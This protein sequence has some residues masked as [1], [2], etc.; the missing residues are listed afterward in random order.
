M[1]VLFIGGTGII[2]S[3]CSKH[4]LANGIDL[5]HLNRGESKSIRPIEG[6]KTLIADVRKPE[7]VAQVIQGHHFDAV[8]DWIAFVPEHIENDIRLFRDKTDQYVFISTA[9]LYQT[10]PEKLPITEE[11]KLENPVW[12]YARN[13]I[14]CEEKLRAE[15]IQSGFP[16]T[17]VRPSHTYDKTLIPM[18]GGYTILKR[19]MD[20]LPVVVHG[21]GASIWTLTHN[22][23]F[24][25]GLIGLLGKKQAINEAYHITS[26]EWQSW[27]TI[28]KTMA[29][30]LG[31]EPD[32]V[33]IPS[34]KIATY[35]RDIGDS[36]LGDKTHSMIFDN[37][38]IKALVPDF[39]AEIPFEQGAQEIAAWYQANPL[40]LEIDQRLNDL[41]EQMI[42]DSR[43][44]SK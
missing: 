29:R 7:E 21:D 20:G 38:K 28:F 40:G 31:V 1:K 4:A 8:V 11:T 35:D 15:F 19:M 30:A 3:A 27:D 6:V 37:S 2:S 22:Q 26:D 14:A 12:E 43:F 18:Q 33:H 23:D 39:K 13:K 17:I 44:G 34:E 9:A 24:A 42:S 32:L 25:K 10:P 41:M 16:Y 36:L 5:Y